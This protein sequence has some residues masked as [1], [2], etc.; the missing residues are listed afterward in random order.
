MRQH[1]YRTTCAALARSVYAPHPIVPSAPGS[2]T[3]L[4]MAAN[5]DFIFW[6]WMRLPDKLD[7]SKQGLLPVEAERTPVVTPRGER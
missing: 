3:F 4:A 1:E 5:A 2:W 7:E 6:T